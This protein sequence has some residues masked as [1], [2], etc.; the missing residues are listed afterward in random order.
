MSLTLN[1]PTRTAA[2]TKGV[3]GAKSL[4]DDCVELVGAW[5]DRAAVLHKKPHA[6]SQRLADLL[7]DPDGPAFALGFVDRVLRPEDLRVA[8]R[9]LRELGKNPPAFLTGVLR[10]LLRLGAWFAPVFPVIVVPIARKALKTLIGHLIIDAS[11]ASL[12][13]TLKRLTK[14]GDQLNINLLGEAVLGAAEANKRF[15]GIERLIERPD[16]TYVSVKVSSVVAQL[17]MWSYDHTADRVV[18]RLVPLYEKAAA[19]NPP[20]FINLDMEEYRDLEMTL[21]VFQRV[22]DRDSLR[23]YYGGIVMQ[24]YLPEA[25][26]AMKRLS[27]FAIARVAAGGAQLKVRVVKGANL[28]MEQVDAAL[29][30]WPVAVLPSK[31]ESDTNYKRVLEWSLTPERA[32]AIRIGVAGHNLFDLAFSHL[33]ATSRGVREHVDFEMLVGMAPD[34]ADA[35]RETV[36][37]LILYTPV[38]HSHEFDAAVGYLV[39][40]LDENASPENFMSAVFDLHDHSDVFAREEARFRAS[41]E[42]MTQKSPSPSRTQDRTLET[43]PRTLAA[44]IEFHN[45]PDTDLALPANQ[46]WARG[47]YR[48]A[49]SAEGQAAGRETLTEGAISDEL[50]TIDGR[51]EID[52]I[53]EGARRSGKK[54]AAKGA[55]ARAKILVKAAAELGVRRG[56]I[57]SVMMQEAGKTLAESDP[58]IS[59]AIDFARYY[60]SQAME[61]EQLEGARFSP[62]GLTVVAPPWNFPVAI[63]TG[64]VTSALAAGSAVIIK[65]APQVRRCAA[66]M[67]E[68]LWAAGVPRDVLRLVDV[69]EGELGRALISHE[70]VDRVILTGGFDTAALFR[71]WRADLPVLAETSGK[72]ALVITPSADIDLAVADLVK[73]AFGHAGQKCSAASLVILVGSVAQSERFWRQLEDA[74]NTLEVGWPQS[75]PETTMNPIIEPPAAK[76]RSGLTELGPGEKWLSEPR[77]LDDTERLWTPGVRLGVAPGSTFHQTEY[78]GPIL[79]VM[80]AKTLKDAVEYQNAVE[81]GLT[82]GIHSLDPDE[83]SYWLDHVDGGNLY[84]NRGITGAIVRRQPFG[85]WKKSSVGP[86]AKAGGPNYLFGFGT[87][88]SSELNPQALAPTV[89]VAPEFHEVL[90]AA[91]ETL[92]PDERE[93]LTQALR[94]DQDAYERHFGASV[95]V[96]QV[97]VERNVFRYRAHEA[98]VRASSLTPLV[99]VLRVVLAGLRAGARVHLSSSDA[100]PESIRQVLATPS[101]ARPALVGVN[102]E[103]ELQFVERVRLDPPERIRLLGGNANVM[104]VHFDGNPAVAVWD[105]DV[106]QSGRVE[107]LPF[108]REQ[109]VSITAHR[110]GAPD[111][112]FLALTV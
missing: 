19:T 78:F 29:H 4:A 80:T 105:H 97:G 66:V 62:V 56:E 24:A 102:V 6:S 50:G 53:V 71:S 63:P 95:D 106:T 18:D 99:D 22:L 110:F 86:T 32:K 94:A 104:Y 64:S 41:L 14:R 10:S 81:Y 107:M 72:N 90:E 49:A 30:D 100:L 8:A 96:S 112:R 89:E 15:E 52:S 98:V 61:M 101:G 58:E 23:N 35:V 79:G 88:S 91:G 3:R 47:I 76:L 103:T 92:G 34:Q 1:S 38:V 46:V 69:S 65:P 67:V 7:K 33:L 51:I 28:Q 74:V 12:E 45:E 48:H 20:T 54:W 84:V 77:Q 9:A 82:A 39:R 85:G 44:P 26:D 57:L 93:S 5:L 31:Q 68:A 87:L 2:S 40:R 37:P 60:A 59:E 73:S 13:R 25:L 11:D 17:S 42:A 108:V 43:R 83:V 75:Q 111:P 55:E 16:V 36:G 109:A 21:D 27:K 70:G